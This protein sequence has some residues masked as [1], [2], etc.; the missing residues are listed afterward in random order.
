M[1]IRKVSSQKS[2]LEIYRNYES[3][4]LGEQEQKETH[5]SGPNKD[6]F[7]SLPDLPAEDPIAAN[8]SF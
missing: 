4:Q 1:S 5:S 8:R 7:P 6:P 2:F 3:F